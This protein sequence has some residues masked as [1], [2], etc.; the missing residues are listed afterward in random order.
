MY[1]ADDDSKYTWIIPAGIIAFLLS[2]FIIHAAYAED[3]QVVVDKYKIVATVT[4]VD[5]QR[6][7][8]LRYTPGTY[9]GEAACKDAI[10][11]DPDFK[12]SQSAL[13]NSLPALGMTDAFVVFSCEPVNDSI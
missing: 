1:D 7:G 11:N 4:S 12:A 2:C 10:E 13:A 3:L 8:K 9:N 5:G 6:S